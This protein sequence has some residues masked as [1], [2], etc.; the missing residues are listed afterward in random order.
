MPNPFTLLQP[1]IYTRSSGGVYKLL[2]LDFSG[3]INYTS[4]ELGTCQMTI[5]N[6]LKRDQVAGDL[7]VT[8][9]GITFFEGS[10]RRAFWG[11]SSKVTNTI[12]LEATYNLKSSAI[13]LQNTTLN[14]GDLLSQAVPTADIYAL[15]NTYVFPP[16]SSDLRDAQKTEILNSRARELAQKEGLGDFTISDLGVFSFSKITNPRILNT[17]LHILQ[18]KVEMG[19]MINLDIIPN[20]TVRPFDQFKLK[21]SYQNI[22]SG[23]A[24]SLIPYVVT[25]TSI[26]F[27]SR[28]GAVQK[29]EAESI[30]YNKLKGGNII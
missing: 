19:D 1:K 3:S 27:N 30:K 17:R 14:K 24:K 12:N 11:T 16:V 6:S 9:G 18:E 26:E 7:R 13:P 21:D 5:F 23:F 15:K 10:V 20:A 28:Q 25:S 29:I 4:R 22:L 2:A 8:I